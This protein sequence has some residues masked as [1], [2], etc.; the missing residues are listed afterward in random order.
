MSIMRPERITPPLIAD[1][2]LPH[3]SARMEA[4]IDTTS[5]VTEETPDAISEEL[6][7]E[8]PAWSNKAGAYY[9]GQSLSR[10]NNRGFLHR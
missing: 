10:K 5:I 8:M 2:R 6:D 7:C 9:L 3:L 4:G 1:V